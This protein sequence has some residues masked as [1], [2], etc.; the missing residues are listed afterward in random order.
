MVEGVLASVSVYFVKLGLW[1]M[2][3]LVHHHCT[4][5]PKEAWLMILGLVL[6]KR[7]IAS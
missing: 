4:S 7:S 2:T 5:R 1:L 3:R 6:G